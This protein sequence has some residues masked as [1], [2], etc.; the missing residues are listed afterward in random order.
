[1]RRGVF[2]QQNLLFA[3]IMRNLLH[4]AVLLMSSLFAGC[5]S[6]VFTPT[7]LPN[8]WADDY[9]SL[10]PMESYQSWGTYNV[11]DPSCRKIGDYYYM[12][13]TDA[14]FRENRKEAKEKGVPLGF[15]QMRRS[16]DLVHWEEIGTAFTEETRPNFVDNN[17]EGKKAALW[18]PEIRYIKGKYVLFYSLAEWGNHW[19]S[20]IGYAVS[21]S[22]EGPFTPKGKVFNSRDVDVENSIDQF[23]YEEDGKYYML[24]GSFRNIYIM[25]LNVTDNLDITPKVETK[26]QLAGNAYEGINLWKRNGYYYLFASIGSC[27][28]GENSTYTTVVAR[29]ENLFGP[30][31][32]KKGEKMLDNAHEI[33]VHKNSRFVGTGHNAILQLDDEGN[34]WMLYHA[35]ELSNL[36]AQRQVLL[37]R[38][39]WDE[40]GWPYV[41]KL[42]PSEN[43]YPPVIK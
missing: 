26:Q 12:Y 6:S 10:S 34:T 37:D 21:D 35:F 3:D 28:E 24:W 4:V 36:G 31:V 14:I 33:V 9:S 19:I 7:A 5:T 11:H 41:D 17:P 22:P 29:S 2:L 27:C 42:E 32:N 38:I 20:T 25:E 16:K 15:I 40:D 23:F 39:L 18:A 8:P 13:S 1:M 43:A 30:Y